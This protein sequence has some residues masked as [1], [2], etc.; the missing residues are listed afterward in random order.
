M[1][2]IIYPYKTKVVKTVI[3]SIFLAALAAFM[4]YTAV[5]NEQ[6]LILNGIIKMGPMGA[7]IFFW[8]ITLIMVFGLA[9]IALGLIKGRGIQRNVVLTDTTISAP[10]SALNN[11][12]VTI[13]YTDIHDVTTQRVSGQHFVN[14][15]H[16]EGKLVISDAML[17][18]KKVF[19]ELVESL[20]QRV[21][22]FRIGGLEPT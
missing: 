8:V 4:G 10:K 9:I 5:T 15:H 11:N 13:A 22:A 12:I 6:G 3:I 1:E 17:P 7:T 2:P 19:E 14:I 20:S 16:P 18:N 21:V